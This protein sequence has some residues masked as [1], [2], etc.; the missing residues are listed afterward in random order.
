MDTKT[1][2]WVAYLTFIGLIIAF[3]TGDKEGAKFHLNQALVITIFAVAG[4]IVIGI[5][6]AVLPIL[7]MLL[8][9]VYNLFIFSYS[10]FN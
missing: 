8:S 5:F 9:V 3:C 2:S 1:T 7:G 4:G 10:I 6:T